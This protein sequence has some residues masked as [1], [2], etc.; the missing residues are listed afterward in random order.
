MGRMDTT[1][2]PIEDLQDG[3]R[4]QLLAEA[5]VVIAVDA[6][7]R[8][9]DGYAVRYAG[10][11]GSHMLSSM[12]RANAFVVLTPERQQVEVG[13]RVRVQLIDPP[14]RIV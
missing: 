7:T 9:E 13:E 4:L 3:S 6:V 10:G 2:V 14:E 5:D 12:A 11:Q 8:D 1:T